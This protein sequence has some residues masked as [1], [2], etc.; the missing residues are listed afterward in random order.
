MFHT[1]LYS[2]YWWLQKNVLFM[3]MSEYIRWIRINEIQVYLWCWLCQVPHLFTFESIAMTFCMR[4]FFLTSAE[5]NVCKPIEKWRLLHVYFG[6]LLSKLDYLS[7]EQVFLFFDRVS[8]ALSC[9]LISLLYL[10]RGINSQVKE[11]R[12]W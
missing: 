5:L 6:A 9:V 8:K 10:S 12:N 4:F 3:W 2:L 7:F 11:C 1:S